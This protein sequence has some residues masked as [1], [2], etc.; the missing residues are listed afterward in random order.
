MTTQ[1]VDD[2]ATALEGSTIGIDLRRQI[3][4]HLAGIRNK[5][6]ESLGDKA[7]NLK[8][9]PLTNYDGVTRS[10]EQR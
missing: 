10:V 9:K 7:R 2:L 5:V 8:L 4:Q 1:L 3:D 6:E